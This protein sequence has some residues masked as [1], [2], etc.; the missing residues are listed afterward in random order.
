VFIE[1]TPTNIEVTQFD[2]F[3]TTRSNR[4]KRRLLSQFCVSHFLWTSLV[5]F[6]SP[7]GSAS[8]AIFDRP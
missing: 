2:P 8:A 4:N 3:A 7:W 5:A 1:P 6:P